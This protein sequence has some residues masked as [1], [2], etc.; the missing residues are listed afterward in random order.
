MRGSPWAVRRRHKRTRPENGCGTAL[1]RNGNGRFRLF[2]SMETR[3]H[4]IYSP[5]RRLH[6]I[7]RRLRLP[8]HRSVFH[9][10][11][12]PRSGPH[13]NPQDD[14]RPVRL[15][16]SFPSFPLSSNHFNIKLF[17]YT[18][19]I[20]FMPGEMIVTGPQ[21]TRPASDPKPHT[22]I[23]VSNRRCVVRGTARQDER[24]ASRTVLRVA[25][26]RLSHRLRTP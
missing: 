2:V 5:Y 16:F 18:S 21:A 26:L 3:D 7:L 13:I 19:T 14:S 11:T 12:A 25:S 8:A 17:T 20:R 10:P 23:S 22:W 6:Q 15:P 1:S 4:E 9:D 24:R